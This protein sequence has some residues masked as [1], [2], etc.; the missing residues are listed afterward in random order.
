MSEAQMVC[1]LIEFEPRDRNVLFYV[2]SVG[3]HRK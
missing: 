2:S 1:P 3:T